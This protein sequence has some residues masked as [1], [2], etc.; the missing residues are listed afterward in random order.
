MSR[1]LVELAKARGASVLMD[2]EMAHPFMDRF[3]SVHNRRI[4]AV[5]SF[6]LQEETTD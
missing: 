3:M 5:K 6:L 4:K 1:K 2:P